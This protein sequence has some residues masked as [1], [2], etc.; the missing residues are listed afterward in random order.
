[1][2]TTDLQQL[3][4]AAPAHRALALAGLT[5]L[6]QLSQKTEQQVAAMHGIGKNAIATLKAALS[7]A[8]LAFRS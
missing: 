2:A 5:T 1:M 3:R 4:L 8:G 7:A 6:A